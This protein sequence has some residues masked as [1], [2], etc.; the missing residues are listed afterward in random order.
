[1]QSC[2]HDWNR[3]RFVSHMSLWRILNFQD[4][5]DLFFLATSN[6]YITILNIYNVIKILQRKGRNNIFL[7]ITI[8]FDLEASWNESSSRRRILT[9]SR[10]LRGNFSWESNLFFL[11][12][13]ERNK[14]EFVEGSI[15]EFLKRHT[16]RK[17]GW[18]LLVLKKRGHR[19]RFI[20][21]AIF[22][23]SSTSI[24]SHFYSIRVYWQNDGIRIHLCS[25]SKLHWIFLFSTRLSYNVNRNL[26][27]EERIILEHEHN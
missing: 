21:R 12:F 5:E 13:L 14:W 26:T 10:K 20:P 24:F 18:K 16:K 19:F 6:F 11:L 15:F 17:R 25:R 7:Y 3:V 22:L 2:N 4:L 27:E 9:I 8:I 23:P 1:M